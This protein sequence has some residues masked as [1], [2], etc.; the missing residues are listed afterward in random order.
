MLISLT[1]F[2]D[3][4]SNTW[5]SKIVFDGMAQGTPYF[6]ILLP[7]LI[8]LTILLLS[9]ILKT[10]FKHIKTPVANEKIKLY[11]RSI[12]YEKTKY[13]DLI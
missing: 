12:L 2:V 9:A 6:N 1:A 4:I 8:L 10:L 5:L 13:L 3:T 11:I 7:I